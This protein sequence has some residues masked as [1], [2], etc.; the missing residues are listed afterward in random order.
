MITEHSLLWDGKV[1]ELFQACNEVGDLATWVELQDLADAEKSNAVERVKRRKLAFH[2]SLGAI[3]GSPMKRQQKVATVLAH[4]MS[5]H[6]FHSLDNEYYR[7]QQ[8]LR[9]QCGC[10]AKGLQP[11]DKCY[12]LSSSSATNIVDHIARSVV[13]FIRKLLANVETV[14]CTVD[15]WTDI[16]G[17]KVC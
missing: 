2:T 8:S 4:V 10:T 3:A 7:A 1:N 5:G 14:A 16:Q 6:S 17:R 9:A 13:C 12:V 11:C 15:N